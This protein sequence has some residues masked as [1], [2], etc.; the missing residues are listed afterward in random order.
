MVEYGRMG[1]TDDY[2]M[3]VMRFFLQLSIPVCLVQAHLPASVEA[4]DL[5]AKIAAHES[6]LEY[7]D[8]YANSLAYAHFAIGSYNFI[9]DRTLWYLFG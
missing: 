1:K 2:I 5:V 4:H 7:E 6:N 8:V 9:F 3:N